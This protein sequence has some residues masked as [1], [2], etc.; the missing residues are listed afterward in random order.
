LVKLFG[1]ATVISDPFGRVWESLNFR[2]PLQLLCE[3]FVGEI[4]L[5]HSLETPTVEVDC[6]TLTLGI[7]VLHHLL[8][9]SLLESVT[10]RDVTI[11]SAVS[12]AF[13]PVI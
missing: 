12:V 3:R 2:V 5:A 13:G 8:I 9:Y 10:S 6:V 1:Y 7:L 11:M 4:V